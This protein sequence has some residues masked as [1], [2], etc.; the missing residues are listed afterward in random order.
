MAKAP[1]NGSLAW[2][3]VSAGSQVAM[4]VAAG[5]IIGASVNAGPLL[6]T[7]GAL[8]AGTAATMFV[9]DIISRNPARRMKVAFENTGI[10]IQ[11][12]SGIRL[13]VLRDRERIPSGWRLWYKV[14]VGLAKKH[15]DDKRDEIEAAL[16][17]EVSFAWRKGLLRV[18]I[19]QG[20]IPREVDFEKPEGMKGEIPFTVGYGRQGIITADLASCPHLLVSGQTGAGK[21]NFCHSLIASMPEEVALYIIDL[22]EVE[23]AYLERSVRVESDIDGSIA[24]LELLTAE[25]H[26]RKKL[27][28]AAGVRSAKDYRRKHELPY[29][30]LVVDEFSQLCPHLAKEKGERDAKNYAHRMLV[31][32][33]SLARSLGIHVVISTQYPHSDILPGTLKQHLPATIAFKTRDDTGSKVCLGNN[34]AAKLPSPVDTPGRAIWQHVAEQEVQTMHLPEPGPRRGKTLHP[35]VIFSSPGRFNGEI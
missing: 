14:P 35:S 25:M 21:S 30:V 33:L 3:L 31:D 17:G 26:R 2:S 1:K 29:Q 5:G 11:R 7:G 20:E 34:R 24:V 10:Y 27:L 12:E 28:K 8:C 15:F 32:L 6:T 18:D 16:D 9:H 23:F 4:L 13:P 22:K 19:V